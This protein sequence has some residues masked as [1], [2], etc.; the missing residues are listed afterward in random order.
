[1]NYFEKRALDVEELSFLTSEKYKKK[2]K[3]IYKDSQKQ[4]ESYISDF[5]ANYADKDG[6]ITF[7]EAKK[8]LSPLE[9]QEFKRGLIEKYNV[10][11]NK[12][13]KIS[14]WESLLGQVKYEQENMFKQQISLFNGAVEEIYKT[15]YYQSVY[16]VQSGTGLKFGFAHLDTKTIEKIMSYKIGD[17]PFSKNIWG[18]ARKKLFADVQKRL[19]IGIATGQGNRE[20][21][22]A[23]AEKYNV[24]LSNANRLIRT[25]ANFYHGQASLDAYNECDTEYYIFIATLDGRTSKECRALDGEVFRLKDAVIGVN[26]NP[27]HPNCRSTTGIHFPDISDYKNR[28]MRDK[29]GKSVDGD[30]MTYSEWEKENGI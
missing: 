1:M 20:V 27:L 12:R 10:D 2:L 30:Y 21:A 19:S 11:I 17:E 3:K 16:T 23:I 29:N 18:N 13:A 6:K 15:S 25:E 22:R 28:V 5:Y 7:Q 9:L 26:Y 8:M 4:L 14:R 24:S